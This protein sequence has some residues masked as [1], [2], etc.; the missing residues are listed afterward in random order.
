M[1]IR[2]LDKGDVGYCLMSW[3]SSH[4]DVTR[5]KPW[6]VYKAAYGPIFKKI[7]DDPATVLLGAYEDK[8]IG[9]LAMTPGKR[10]D[11]LHWCY[12]KHELD[13]E[14]VRRRG[15]MTALLEEADL[16]MNFVYT[17][18]PRRKLDEALVA[19]LKARGVTACF[20]PMK[21]WLK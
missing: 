4:K 13:G 3:Y 20:V 21:D 15:V 14:H 17:L 6:H 9:W 18:R 11:T 12:T 7:V 1:I 10:V 8:L 5:I 19:A 2:P 16:G